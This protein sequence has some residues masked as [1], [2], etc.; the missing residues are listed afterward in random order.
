MKTTFKE[1]KMV[2]VNCDSKFFSMFK[3]IISII[4]LS[5]TGICVAQISTQTVRGVISDKETKTSIQNAFVQISSSEKKYTG[6]TNEQGEFQIDSVLI[7]RFS[8]SVNAKNYAGYVQ[9][10]LILN[11]AKEA[12][13]VINLEVS[14]ALEA[15]QINVT[16]T[17]PAR[18]N[19]DMVTV[20][21]RQFST[22][23]TN[24]YAGS[25]MDPSRMA[26]NFAGVNGGGDSE[27]IS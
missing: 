7:G 27:M 17:D 5:V 12:V 15:V 6:Y 8:L 21:G 26:A 24:R 4:C 13:L 9:K 3:H 1:Y 20:S 10:D 16:K 22:D 25:L 23:Q 14:I 19:N 2:L 11:S 18:T